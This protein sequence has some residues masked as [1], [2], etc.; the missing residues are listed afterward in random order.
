MNLSIDYAEQLDLLNDETIPFLFLTGNAGTGKSTLINHFVS[1]TK[2]RVVKLAPT[3]IAALR[4]SGET[5]HRFFGLPVDLPFYNAK[6]F[7]RINPGKFDSFDV[8]V[9][10]EI[11]MV[12]SDMMRAVYNCLTRSDKLGRPWGGKM[13]RVV[14]DLCQLPPVVVDKDC[15]TSGYLREM[16]GGIY[17]FN[18]GVFDQIP[19][20]ELKKVHRQ[21]DERFVKMLNFMRAPVKTE[22]HIN[23]L[24]DELNKLVKPASSDI[25]RLCA[26]NKTADGINFTQINKLRSQEETYSGR[27]TG[28]IGRDLPT[29][30]ELTLKVGCKVMFV[31]NTGDFKNGEIGTVT[32]LADNYIWVQKKSGLVVKVEPYMWKKTKYEVA[33]LTAYGSGDE[34]SELKSVNE[35]SFIQLPVRLAYAITIHKSQGIT[36]DQAHIDLGFGAFAHGQTY[37]AMSRVTGL[38]GLSLQSRIKAKDFIFDREIY[39]DRFQDLL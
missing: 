22:A 28:S 38:D 26:T 32:E 4:I 5:L 17:F 14:G 34:D 35:A 27:I 10:D 15:D 12:R 30:Q 16:Y 1:T 20:I 7:Q 39:S 23:Y 18:C 6:T 19:R 13:V 11:S 8:V 3:G 25:T 24:V 29:D 21:K 2:K 9:I 36:L 37:V 31:A 33:S